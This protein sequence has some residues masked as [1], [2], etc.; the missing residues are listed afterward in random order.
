M[1]NQELTIYPK[2]R[3]AVQALLLFIVFT[4]CS[5][6]VTAEHWGGWILALLGA[7]GG[8]FSVLMMTPRYNY[9]RLFA[10]GFE[11]RNLFKSDRYS[12][13]DVER[14]ALYDIRGNGY[15][16]AVFIFSQTGGKKTGLGEM[17]AKMAELGRA[18]DN[19]CSRCSSVNAVDIDY[20]L[21]RHYEKS[22]QEIVEVMNEWKGKY[23][24]N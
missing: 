22:P 15:N 18:L 6:A 20:Y 24:S 12:W 1:E 21:P 5:L 9:L 2:K 16:L 11:V 4:I 8:I 7:V 3:R 10:E 23:S 13:S 14:I 17:M 19:A